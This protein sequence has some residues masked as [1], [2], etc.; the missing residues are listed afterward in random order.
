MQTMIYNINLISIPLT[1]LNSYGCCEST[2]E[3]FNTTPVPST[4]KYMQDIKILEA[5]DVFS[6]CKNLVIYPA[7]KNPVIC[8]T[9]FLKL[10]NTK[11]P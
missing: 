2:P 11:L 8:L 10:K 7:K 3:K 4:W 5:W 6:W 9:E 1:N